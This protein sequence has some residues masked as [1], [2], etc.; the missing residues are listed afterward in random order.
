MRAERMSARAT[1]HKRPMRRISAKANDEAW[2]ALYSNKYWRWVRVRHCTRT[3][4]REER[5]TYEQ[6][7]TKDEIWR[8]ARQTRRGVV[9]R[10]MKVV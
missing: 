5:R 1:A 6:A 9:E 4:T 7:K 8:S 3:S 2:V 10:T